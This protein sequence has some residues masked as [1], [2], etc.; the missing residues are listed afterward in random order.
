MLADP[1]AVE[2]GRVVMAA[3]ARR[4][5][6]APATTTADPAI[7]PPA[8][9]PD[10]WTPLV[11]YEA[12]L[13]ST[14]T[15]VP[16]SDF[17]T[18]TV[19][20]ELTR[21][22]LSTHP[23]DEVTPIA[24]GTLTTGLDS[25]PMQEVSGRFEF[26][27]ALA[28]SSNPA[29]D[30]IA[31]NAMDEEWLLDVETRAMAFFTATANSTAGSVTYGT[32]AAYLTAIRHAQ[33]FQRAVARRRVTTMVAPAA[34]Y[35]VAGDADDST[36]RPLLPYGPAVNAIGESGRA[37]E[38]LYVNG[39]PL[40]PQQAAVADKTLVLNDADAFGFATPVM[41]FRFEATGAG[42][43][44]K[45]LALVK[46]SGVGFWTRRKAGV[47]CLTNSTPLAPPLPLSAGVGLDDGTDDDAKHKSSK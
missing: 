34:E 39:V 43:D 29:I 20:R 41:Q 47:V 21:T 14:L 12:P 36:N 7:V 24:A 11:A 26:S 4:I 42:P 28:M 23:V 46:Y 8:Y 18:L 10:L 40:V 45:V 17:T 19:P 5:L 1:G 33:A 13:W 32:G 6:A 9:R 15:K 2:R 25:V 22:G 3:A 16:V 37:I 44:P 35:V 30:M 27:R 31:M 38:L